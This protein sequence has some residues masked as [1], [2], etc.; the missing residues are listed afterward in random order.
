MKN[1]RILKYDGIIPVCHNESF[2][3]HGACVIGQVKLAIKSS[4]WYNTVLRA[5]IGPI[6][7]GAYTNIQDN[8]L[9]HIDFDGEAVIGEYVTIGHNVNL[10]NAFVKNNTLIGNG[11]I[12]LDNVEIGSNVL[13]GAGTI[14]PPR[15]KIPD[16]VLVMGN[17]FKIVRELN[18]DEVKFIRN[19]AL[20][21][22][23][24]A[25]KHAK[26]SD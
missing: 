20:H 7:I 8:S 18:E 24:L 10:H 17:P 15:K 5:D 6:E 23:D 3:A 16:N 22:W 21:Y 14:I 2:I 25:L 9:I 13:I 26:I 11:A 4:I 19:N 1:G 12:I